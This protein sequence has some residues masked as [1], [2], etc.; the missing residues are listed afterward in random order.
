MYDKKITILSKFKKA[1][2]TA[3]TVDLWKKTVLT[4]AEYVK[5]TASNM[6]GSTIY[7]TYQTKV[8]IPFGSGYLP[9]SEWIKDT[10]K[11]F[12][13]SQGDLII[14]GYVTETPT[15][16]NITAIKTKYQDNLC[17]VKSIQIMD[18]E[19]NNVEVAIEGV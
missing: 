12:A 9:Y 19:L 15:Y 6:Q 2:Q 8:L 5:K 11:G 13:V 3:G 18:K 1:D 10:T 4:N 7:Y 17:D 14:F 16:S